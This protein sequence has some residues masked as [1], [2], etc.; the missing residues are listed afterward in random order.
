MAGPVEPGA[1][2]AGT[3]LLQGAPA[4]A[5]APSALELPVGLQ[6]EATALP[7]RCTLVEVHCKD[8]G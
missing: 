6:A 8:R 3:V 4:L 5:A 7:L 2:G 1:G